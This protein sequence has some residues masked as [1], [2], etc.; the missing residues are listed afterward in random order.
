MFTGIIEEI[1]TI[2]SIK[3]TG[4]SGILEVN[5]FKVLE[6]THIGDSIAVNGVCLTVTSVSASGFVADVI[7]E[8]MNR[9]NLGSLRPGN[10]LN[11]ERAMQLGGRL[12]GHMMSGHID[13]T[14]RIIQFREDENAIWVQIELTEN[15][16]R[17][18]V[19]KGS[20]GIDGISLTVAKTDLNSFCV[21]IIPHTRHLTTLCTKKIKDKV[22][23]EIDM[24]ARYV[25]KLITPEGAL[26]SGT[27]KI[28]VDFLKENGYL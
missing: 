23:I 18:V 6:D 1:G 26:N 15:L 11:L 10:K 27:S 14:A 5:A 16:F 12:G 20:V 8:T 21:S 2:Q 17:Y 24:L 22:N 4:H 25:E 28:S 7:P 3:Q 9:T 19:E 13:D